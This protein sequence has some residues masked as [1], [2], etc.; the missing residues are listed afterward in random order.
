M[1]N[2]ITKTIAEARFVFKRIRSEFE[3]NLRYRKNTAKNLKKR[4]KL[5]LVY[6]LLKSRK[7]KGIADTNGL[8]NDFVDGAL[9]ERILADLNEFRRKKS[10]STI[11]LNMET[12]TALIDIQ[13]AEDLGD[14]NAVVELLLDQYGWP[15]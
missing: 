13:K 14:V 8:F 2:N 1:W 4:E 12:K 5:D 9:R 11:R 7:K 10:S 6:N 3:G 15:E